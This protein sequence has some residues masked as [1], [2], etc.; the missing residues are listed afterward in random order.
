MIIYLHIGLERITE[1]VLVIISR[2]LII[3]AKEL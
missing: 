2:E 1:M 3:F